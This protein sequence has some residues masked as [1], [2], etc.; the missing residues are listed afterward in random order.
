MRH[1][2]KWSHDSEDTHRIGHG[3]KSIF[4]TNLYTNETTLCKR[5][6]YRLLTTLDWNT[7]ECKQCLIKINQY[8]NRSSKFYE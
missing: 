2:I 4:G 7:V 8:R 3:G 5:D 6:S 1:A